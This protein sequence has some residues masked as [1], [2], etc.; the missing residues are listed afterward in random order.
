MLYEVITDGTNGGAVN[1]KSTVVG[2]GDGAAGRNNAAIG[3]N[4]GVPGGAGAGARANQ[5][6]SFV[7]GNGGNGQIKLTYSSNPTI[8]STPVITSYSIHYTKLYDNETISEMGFS[9][10]PD[11][12]SCNEPISGTHGKSPV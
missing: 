12:E 9:E 3:N 6:N 10:K 7:G 4:G 2:G 8:S 5:G 11:L 1:T